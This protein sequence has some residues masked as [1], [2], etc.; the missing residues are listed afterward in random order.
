MKLCDEH[1]SR[2]E[3]IETK[4]DTFIENNT[5]QYNK[6]LS[7]VLNM[8]VKNNATITTSLISLGK[9]VAGVVATII[10]LKQI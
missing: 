7:H 9:W 8:N 3:R 10:T 1:S 6:L 4:I 2:L 5:K